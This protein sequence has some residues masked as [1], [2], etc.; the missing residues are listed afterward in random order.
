LG[1]PLKAIDQ[2]TQ[3][4]PLRTQ[5]FLFSE[6]PAIDQNPISVMVGG[7]IIIVIGNLLSACGL[8][9]PYSVS[10]ETIRTAQ[11][12]GINILHYAWRRRQITYTGV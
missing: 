7:G 3:P 6:L 5:P 1:T 9:S 2:F 4:H 12:M 11:E 8:D 10:R